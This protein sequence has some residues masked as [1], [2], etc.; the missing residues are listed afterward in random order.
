MGRCSYCG[1]RAELAHGTCPAPLASPRPGLPRD[2]R[3]PGYRL[4]RVLGGGGFGLVVLAEAEGGAHVALKLALPEAHAALAQLEAEAVALHGI[5]APAVPVLLDR[6]SLEGGGAWLALELIEGETLARR[7]ATAGGPLPAAEFAALAPRML[8]A[9]ERVHEAGFLHLDFKPENVLLAGDGARLV[10]LGL[11]RPEGSPARSGGYAGT[12]EWM[13]PE[14]WDGQADVRADIYAAG[15]VLFEMLTGRVPFF[16]SRAEVEQAHR[17]LRPPRPSDFARVPAAVEE[18]VLR[19]LGKKRAGRPRSARA[20]REELEAALRDPTFAAGGA[21]AGAA[22][23]AE[24]AAAAA[25]RML[26]VVFFRPTRDAGAV[27]AALRALGGEVAHLSRGR[28]VA[29]F[30]C[31]DEPPRRAVV[32]AEELVEAGICVRALVDLAAVRV[33]ERPH[34]PTRL[35]SDRFLRDESYPN[36]GDPR[37]ALVAQ[38]VADLLPSARWES[39]SRAGCLRRAAARETGAATVL[40]LGAGPLV[41]REELLAELLAGA[42]LTVGGAGPAVVSVIAE[43]GYG[44]S[45]LCATLA[46]RLRAQLSGADVLE[47]RVREPVAGGEGATLRALTAAALGLDRAADEGLARARC[48]AELGAGRWPVVASALGLLPPGE[49]SPQGAAAAPGALRSL[50]MRA[51][52]EA[53]RRRAGRRPLCL[54]LDDAQFADDAALDALEDAARSDLA[55]PIWICALGRPAFA[56]ARGSFGARAAVRRT[57]RLGELDPASAAELCRRLLAPAREVPDREVAQ[58]VELA[59]RVPLRLIELTRALHRA[60]LVREQPGGGGVQLAAGA[61]ERLPPLPL[62]DW[63]AAAEL[64]AL[65]PDLASHLRFVA[66][67][68]REVSPK[69]IEGVAAALERVGWRELRLDPGVATARLLSAGALV[70]TREGTV[71]FRHALQREAVA[72]SAPAQMRGPVHRAAALYYAARTGLAPAV[73]AP[74]LALHLA[75][76]GETERA[77][78]LYLRLAEQGRARHEHFEAE[79]AF[80]RALALLPRQDRACRLAALRGRAG[81]RLRLGRLH[82][83][84]ADFAHARRLACEL[85]D[86]AAR[87]ELLLD[88]AAAHDCEGDPL[89]SGARLEE[90]AALAAQTV[91]IAAGG[92]KA[93]PSGPRRCG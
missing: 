28:C 17:A 58:L 2:L 62:L 7:L 18:L 51:A 31:A 57:H 85:G 19:C 52:G 21:G 40:R 61:L 1:R 92:G 20:L 66:L 78:V 23:K 73:R 56:A 34:A 5:G 26:P 67:L 39:T 83:A 44:K 6:G 88:E 84:L 68:G 35:A 38:P 53:L 63:T 14:Q 9:L 45:H 90:A 29:A 74:L 81:A 76:S 91:L 72:A 43:A 4:E 50:W 46:E 8:R 82:D 11:A 60:G 33:Q 24:G 77:A 13:A 87:L 89:R 25:D 70:S 15:V 41:G 3:V 27:L 80:G 22:A 47:M 48:E 75:A 65:P 93:E 49:A 32:A 86:V 36:D 10:D 71:R 79:T 55:A 37:G 69:E 64:D 42:R 54:L 30:P 12:P 16:G 59:Q